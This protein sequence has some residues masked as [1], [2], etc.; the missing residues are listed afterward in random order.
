MSVAARR[1]LRV[2]LRRPRM[3]LPRPGPRTLLAL[4]L[5]GGILVG[6]WFWVRSSSLVAVQRV[7]VTGVSGPDAQAIRATLVRTAERMTT[8]DLDEA[9]L[10]ASV[11]RY[12][13]VR[14]VRAHAHL[15]HSLTIDVAEQVPV[16]ILEGDGSRTTV[17]SQGRLLR[18]VQPGAETLPSIRIAG[19]PTGVTVTSGPVLDEVRMLAAAPYPLLSRMTSAGRV[20]GHGLSV[21]LR[22]GPVIYFGD[23]AQ[24]AAKWRDVVAV[25]A[26]PGSAGASYIDVTVPAR[27]AAGSGADRA[28]AAPGAGTAATSTATTPV[29][30]TTPVAGST[31]AGATAPT[32]TAP[33]AQTTVTTGG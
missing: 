2:P 13:V 24:L 5:V 12:P 11:A 26:S 30:P 28:A 29:T 4:V 17:S 20:R 9:R 7:T 21:A 19:A 16:A 3:R 14:G 10:R 1:R 32:A 6:A 27:P 23:D 33:S 25:L 15:P 22:N 31:G 8:L 18:D